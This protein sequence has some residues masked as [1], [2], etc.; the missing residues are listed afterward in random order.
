VCCSIFP[1]ASCLGRS[2]KETNARDGLRRGRGEKGLLPQ[3]R[4][5]AELSLFAIIFV[6]KFGRA[7]VP[8]LHKVVVDGKRDG[9]EYLQSRFCCDRAESQEL[10]SGRR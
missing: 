6:F 2:G 7:R 9:C 5:A 3:T 8:L 10:C 1:L 4:H